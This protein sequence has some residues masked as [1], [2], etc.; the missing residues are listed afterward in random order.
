MILTYYGRKTS[1]AECRERCGLGRDGLTARTIA[2]AARSYGLRVGAYSLEPGDLPEISLPAIVHWDFNHFVIL[3]RWSPSGVRIVDPAGGRRSLTAEEFDAHFTGV[4]LT[5]EPGAGFTPRRTAA[6]PSLL[7]YVSAYVWRTPGLLA[8]ILAASVLLQVF[9][10][11]LPVFTQVL[12]D[13]VLP[14]RMTNVM[15]ILAGGLGLLLLTQLV[16]GYLRAALL[17]YLQGRLDS[18]MMLGFVE[19]LLALPLPF[20]HQRSSGD[21]VMRLSGNAMI[22]EMLSSQTMSIV[23]DGAFVLGYLAI[24]WALAPVFAL[25]AVGIG[26]FQA[27]LLLGTTRLTHSLTERDLA[28]QAETQSYLVEALKGIATLKAS[29]AEDRAFDRWSKLFLKELTLALQRNQVSAMVE[30]ASSVVRTFAPLALLWVG[31]LRVL[32]G[33]MSLGTMLALNT[34]VVSFLTPLASLTATG[35]RLQLVRAYFD[36]LTDVLDAEPEH[37]D[38]TTPRGTG[39]PLG[40]VPAKP[41]AGSPKPAAGSPRPAAGYP[42][43]RRGTRYPVSRRRGS[44]VGSSCRTSA[45]GTIRM[46]PWRF[47]PSRSPSSAVRRSPW[48]VP[49][50]RARAP[51][52]CCSSVCI[53]QP[54][55]RSSTTACRCLI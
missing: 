4:T 8:Q 26:A 47:I 19:H 55:G 3:E 44:P 14:F 28:A 15:A 20:F 21:L 37:E 32:D 2:D 50:G 33:S 43:L 52:P 16:L 49:R 53:G 39:Y 31:T 54:R 24:L 7:R 11:V 9:G 12:V 30:M 34:L 46:L 35:Q 18:Q 23:L 45:S 38:N 5:F 40:M 13:H 1:V 17:V 48:S 29:G 36:R 27:A 42:S 25:L 41:A 6:Q 22:R 10:L 51:S